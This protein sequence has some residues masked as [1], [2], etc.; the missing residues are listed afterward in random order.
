MR[1]NASRSELFVEVIANDDGQ[2]MDNFVLRKPADW[3]DK[4]MARRDG[5]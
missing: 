3:G 4:Y 2:L 1:M 5:M